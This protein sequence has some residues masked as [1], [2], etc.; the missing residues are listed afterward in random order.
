MYSPT[1][2]LHHAQTYLSAFSRKGLLR[3]WGRKHPRHAAVDDGMTAKPVQRARDVL[4]GTQI[5][6]CALA[7]RPLHPQEEHPD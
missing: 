6:R 4:S 3:A 2:L 7:T 1:I 5:I